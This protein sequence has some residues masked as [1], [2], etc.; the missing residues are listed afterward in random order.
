MPCSGPTDGSDFSQKGYCGQWW[1]GAAIGARSALLSQ[2]I[3]S[4]HQAT[5]NIMTPQQ[6]ITVGFGRQQIKGV[7]T[8]R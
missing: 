8:V 3:L 2:L 5:A 6:L 4:H 1:A 7:C